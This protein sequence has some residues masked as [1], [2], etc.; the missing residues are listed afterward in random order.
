MGRDVSLDDKPAGLY[1]Q[2]FTLLGTYACETGVEDGNWCHRIQCITTIRCRVNRDI[3]WVVTIIEGTHVCRLIAEWLADEVIIVQHL[4]HISS[5]YV[6]A[7][8]CNVG[9]KTLLRFD[10]CPAVACFNQLQA[11]NTTNRT[12]NSKMP[13]I[14]LCTVLW[15][16]LMTPFYWQGYIVLSPCDC[17]V[18]ANFHNFNRWSPLSILWCGIFCTHMSLACGKRNTHSGSQAKKKKKTTARDPLEDPG[19][20]GRMTLRWILKDWMRQYQWDQYG[21]EKAH[22]GRMN[23]VMILQVPEV[24]R[25]FWLSWNC[26]LMKIDPVPCS[27]L[28]VVDGRPACA[29][30][31]A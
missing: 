15:T 4:Q 13:H 2:N 10:M 1:L 5:T 27:W 8:I 26:Q 30:L 17:T 23:L 14:H 25:I 12:D 21:S 18:A 24:W 20:D 19:I 22:M 29:S 11:G 28:W 7:G 16:Q 9:T 31:C 3:V 6:W